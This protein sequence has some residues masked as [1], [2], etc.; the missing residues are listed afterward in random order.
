MLTDTDLRNLGFGHAWRE[1]FFANT[2]VPGGA[3]LLDNRCSGWEKQVDP[4]KFN[5]LDVLEQLFGSREA[6]RQKLRLPGADMYK[7]LGFVVFEGTTVPM[8]IAAWTHE[9][10]RRLPKNQATKP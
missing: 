3:V 9:V 5:E 6:A 1:R 2:H 10:N 7:E 4:K 8:L